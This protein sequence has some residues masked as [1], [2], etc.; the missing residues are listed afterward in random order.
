MKLEINT[1]TT[2]KD[3]LYH[4]GM[5][6]IALSGKQGHSII[7]PS[8]SVSQSQPQSESGLMNMFASDPL[9]SASPQQAPQQSFQQ[10]SHE[11]FQQKSQ[12]NSNDLFSLFK[13]NPPNVASESNTFDSNEAD[14]EQKV[15]KVDHD[16][17]DLQLIPY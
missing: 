8:P 12:Q 10:H 3:S 5:M 2:P 6:L 16:D 7:S 9:L 13:D 1:E 4:L 17:S 14:Q 11:S 15:D